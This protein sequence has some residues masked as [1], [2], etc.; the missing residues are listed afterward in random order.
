MLTVAC[1][2]TWSDV[3]FISHVT[4]ITQYVNENWNERKSWLVIHHCCKW[5]F[6]SF[7]VLL[8]NEYILCGYNCNVD[9]V[10]YSVLHLTFYHSRFSVSLLQIRALQ[11]GAHVAPSIVASLEE[12][13]RE[14]GEV[15]SGTRLD[16]PTA[17]SGWVLDGNSF[18]YEAKGWGKRILEI[19]C[20]HVC[21]AVSS[22]DPMDLSPLGSSV[23]EISQAR[24]LEW[25]AISFARGSSPPRGICFS[26]VS[27]ISR[28]ILYYCTSWEVPEIVCKDPFFHFLSRIGIKVWG[29]G[30]Q[31]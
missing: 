8:P 12:A 27:C 17:C 14:L 5:P 29:F 7:R 11:P 9:I 20:M 13:W 21:S 1:S 25:V 6:S 18:Y 19:V 31:V 23:H 3:S 15:Y 10:P 26:C 16:L 4:Q 28:W 2:L 30:E 24:I 22:S